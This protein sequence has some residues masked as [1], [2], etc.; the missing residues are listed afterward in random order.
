M[1][2][3][4][5]EQASAVAKAAAASPSP[6]A[7]ASPK[8]SEEPGSHSASSKGSAGSSDE[9]LGTQILKILKTDA[10]TVDTGKA[11]IE[12]ITEKRK[13]LVS[14]R[15]KLTQ[16]LRNESRKRARIRARS[17]YLTNEDLVQVLTMRK[18]KEDAAQAKCKARPSSGGTGTP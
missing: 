2:S 9:D 13:S 15:K 12:E 18:S 1:A 11:K 3:A 10:S 5:G 17:Q 4:S 8:P 6:K 7:T 14:E 16:E